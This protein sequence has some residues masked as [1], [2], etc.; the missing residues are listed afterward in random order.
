M[1]AQQEEVSSTTTPVV[2]EG[3]ES[4][5]VSAAMAEIFSGH[6]ASDDGVSLELDREAPLD[7][8]TPQVSKYFHI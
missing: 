2:L 3:S 7:S 8:P 6:E 4:E 1:A 5:A